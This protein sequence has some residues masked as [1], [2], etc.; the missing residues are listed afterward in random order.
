M[1]TRTLLAA[2]TA[3][4]TIAAV[5]VAAPAAAPAAARG[6]SCRSPFAIAYQR[7]SYFRG[8]IR[9][10][11]I[12]SSHRSIGTGLSRITFRWRGLHRNRICSVVL[13]DGRGRPHRLRSARTHGTYSFRQGEGPF[14]FR[15]FTITA[16][17]HR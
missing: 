14:P 6:S 5:P 15:S 1:R 13:V 16:A 11:R 10:I 4:G 7:G 12:T 2:A 8:D 9:Q 3:A 17:R